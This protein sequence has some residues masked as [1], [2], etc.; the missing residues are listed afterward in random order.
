MLQDFHYALR[1]LVKSRSYTVITVTVLALAIGANAAIFSFV[2]AMLLRPLPY[3]HADRLYAPVSINLARNTDQGSVSFAD[4]E[5]WKREKD[6]FAEVA[7]ANPAT[8]DLTGSGEP[9]RIDGLQ[10]TEEY[11]RLT[12]VRPLHGRVF[13][14]ADQA[15]EAPRVVIISYSLWQRRFGGS[16]AV[17]GTEVRIGGVPATVIGV[18]PPRATWPE[19]R[20]IFLP[21]RTSLFNA[22]VRTRRDNLIFQAMSRLA[23]GA[24]REQVEARMRAIAARVA[25]ENPSSRQG[26]TNGLVPLREYII[27]ADLRVALLVLMA[28]V[29]AVLLI[30][31]AN[32]A[33]LA[34][35][36]G[37]GRA[38]EISLRLALGA[39][40]SRLIRQLLAEA[41][42]LAAAG[43][44][45]GVA[46]AQFMIDGLRSFAP[47]TAPFLNQ[48][49]IDTRVVLV[50]AALTL[51]TA[52]LFGVLPAL[53]ASGVRVA[54][55]LKEGAR[56]SS[57]GRRT[58]R[59]RAVLVV[60]EISTAVVLLVV[61][62]LLARSLNRLTM[63]TPGADLDRVLSGRI[64]L[65]GARY[66]EARTRAEFVRQLTERLAAEPGIDAAA[67]TTYLPVGG[68]GFG[69]GRVFLGDGWPEPPA[70][71]DVPAMWTVISP[72]YFRTLGI[73]VVSGRAFGARDT[74]TSTPVIVVSETF[75]RNAFGSS[76]PLGRRIR[77]WRDENMYREIVGVVADVPF[78]SLADRGRAV[79]YIPYQ[80]DSW[81]ALIVT[82][83]AAQG[84][85][86][87][88]TGT[89]RRTVG[90]LDPDIALARVGAMSL[91]ARE[92]IARE[93]VST[94]L[95]TLLALA[96]LVLSALG[97][98]GVMSY[99]V[100]ERRQEMGVRLA[101]GASPRDLY[102]SV[103]TQGLGLTAAGLGS[104]LVLAIAA[105][106][107]LAG[108]LY[109]T[110]PFDAVAFL[111]TSAALAVVAVLACWIP[112]R[113]A[114]HAD[115][116]IA[117]RNE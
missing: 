92:S 45:L 79:V 81:N 3:P 7:L 50:A 22:D 110:S 18:L 85:P 32:L 117:L 59:L 29:V 43:G 46:L 57:Q 116:L 56:G 105:A 83:R 14:S 82:V 15:A 5:D 13:Q 84:S 99:S 24:T 12:G 36:R 68:G 109:G 4:Y 39:R 30:A 8:V 86:E 75:A 98:Y 42:Q 91:F 51:L 89:L 28:A 66:P 60:A 96:A 80:Q 58:G 76:S 71:P 25:Q 70:G 74:D 69:L 48:V 65:P 100:T 90:S 95:M 115:P 107:L 104:G 23:E 47:P 106:R 11:F 111:A 63:E 1:T 78:S 9:E 19:D 67:V 26:W 97:I 44:A 41:L 77:S 102:R 113:R 52:I 103:L 64:T 114:A 88:L 2:D 6:L 33:S 37:A 21:M 93:R 94:T 87:I 27:D 17:A 38:R 49:A 31:C 108:L 35:V 62:G 55:A 101:L 16:P 54:E 73:R 40:R 61:A 112:A 72:D 34:L 10:V 53:T 20:E